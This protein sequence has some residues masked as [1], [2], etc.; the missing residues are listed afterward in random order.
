MPKLTL[1]DISNKVYENSLETCEYISGYVD[2]TSTITVKCLIHNYE[3]QTKF[4]NVRNNQRKHHH[5]CPLC[6]KQDLEDKSVKIE[7]ECAYCRQKFM[8]VPSKLSS[9]RSKSGLFFCCREHKDLAQR[10]ESGL[11]FEKIRPSH[12]G[13]TE[14]DYRAKA[15]RFYE[16]KCAV[17]SWDEDIDILEVHHIDENRNNNDIEN[18]K[19]LCPI[20]HRK[21]TSHKYL[22]QD[23]EIV[24]Q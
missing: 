19:I 3:F 10:I 14:K 16:N 2:K 1:K 21:I 20:C 7:Y 8:R 24:K 23:N 5:I 17:C 15:F 22:L 11:E 18:L 12:Y 9:E 4:E 13:T 6:K